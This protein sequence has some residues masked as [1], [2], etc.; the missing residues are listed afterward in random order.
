MAVR[1]CTELTAVSPR[2]PS[3][4]PEPVEGVTRHGFRGLALDPGLPLRSIRGD[5]GGMSECHGMSGFVRFRHVRP[6]AG[7]GRRAGFVHIMF[8]RRASRGFC[9]LRPE[10][11]PR[12]ARRQAKLTQAQMAPPM[13]M[14]LSVYR[15]RE[16]GTRRVSGP[17]ATLLR[18]IR[19]EPEAVR[20]ALSS[21]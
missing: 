1:T 6:A 19:K 7:A 8:L 11:D 13:G 10:A 3:R 2:P 20:R 18:V 15:K 12:E 9:A 14:S 21:P 17:A 16:Q 5:K 4:G